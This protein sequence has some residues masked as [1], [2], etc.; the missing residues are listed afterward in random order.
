MP[1]ETN[2]LCQIKSAIQALQASSIV[3]TNCVGDD[4]ALVTDPCVLEAITALTAVVAA[5][6]DTDDD[7]RPV[8]PKCYLNTTKNELFVGYI[9]TTEDGGASTPAWQILNGQAPAATDIVAECPQSMMYVEPICVDLHDG[10]GSVILRSISAVTYAE[11]WL[12]RV[13]KADGTVVDPGTASGQYTISNT[14]CG[15]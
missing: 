3:A 15:A 1:I 6:D 10:N 7:V 13:E 8:A 4:A 14:C 11:S 12:V 5:K 2:I 9:T